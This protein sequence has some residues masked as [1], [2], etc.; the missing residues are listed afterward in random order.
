MLCI[1]EL[2]PS[3]SDSISTKRFVSLATYFAMLLFFLLIYRFLWLLN[4]QGGG[5]GANVDIMSF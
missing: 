1:K 4:I 5:K 2:R 3:Q